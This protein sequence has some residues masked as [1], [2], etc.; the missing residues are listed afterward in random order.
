MPAD[1]NKAERALRHIVL[2]RRTSH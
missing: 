2:K 1:N